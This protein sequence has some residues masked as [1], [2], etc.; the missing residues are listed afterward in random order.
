MTLLT[1]DINALQYLFNG[2]SL[3]LGEDQ[4][5]KT[6]VSTP[7]NAKKLQVVCQNSAGQIGQKEKE[8][9]QKILLAV[10]MDDKSYDIR[11]VIDMEPI[12]SYRNLKGVERMIVFADNDNLTQL[13][14][15][16][17]QKGESG[18][19]KM[20][21]SQPLGMLMTDTNAKRMLWTALKGFFA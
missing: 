6:S 15:T 4:Q 9:L 2:T 3:L 12:D 20:L 19:V 16:P 10:N 11:Q 7:N 5:Q 1:D 21:Y 14:A 17:Y 18:H 8:L 13:N